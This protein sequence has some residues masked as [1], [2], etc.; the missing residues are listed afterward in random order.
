MVDYLYRLYLKYGKEEHMKNHKIFTLLSLF[1]FSIS[2][3]L[4][5]NSLTDS[6][7]NEIETRVIS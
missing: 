3:N 6:Q 1:V 5:S 2:F 4:Y 7:I